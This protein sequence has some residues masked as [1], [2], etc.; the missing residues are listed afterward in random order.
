[1][2]GSVRRSGRHRAGQPNA[3]VHRRVWDGPA[4]AEAERLDREWPAW[5]V[6]YSL[7]DRRFYALAGWAAPVPLMVADDT[8]E[9]LEERMYDAETAFSRREIHAR[10]WHEV[11]PSG[12]DGARSHVPAVSP[13]RSRPYRDAA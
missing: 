11:H 1:M 13:Y 2:I 10:S 5:L 9:G 6:L 7:G 8:A 4:R 3:T 12:R